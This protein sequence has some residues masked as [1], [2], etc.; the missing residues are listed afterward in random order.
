MGDGAAAQDD[1]LRAEVAAE[2]HGP[3]GDQPGFRS[4]PHFRGPA[5]PGCAHG[6][7][8]GAPGARMRAPAGVTRAP[9][10]QCLPETAWRR[11]GSAPGGTLVSLSLE[12]YLGQV[13]P[14]LFPSGARDVSKTGPGWGRGGSA[15]LQVPVQLLLESRLPWSASGPHY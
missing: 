10:L 3:R 4:A 5:P 14:F 8:Q 9:G 6:D 2:T 1:L 13:F 12:G 7:R 11:G 15:P